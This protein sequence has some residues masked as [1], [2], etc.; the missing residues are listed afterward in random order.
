MI[1]T[2]AGEFESTS[3]FFSRKSLYRKDETNADSN[4]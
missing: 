3:P 1:K 2:T 4:P